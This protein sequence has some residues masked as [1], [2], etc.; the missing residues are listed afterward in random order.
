ML[1]MRDRFRLGRWRTWQCPECHVAYQL[2]EP[3]DITFWQ[4]RLRSS[5][6]KHSNLVGVSL[7]CRNCGEVTKFLPNGETAR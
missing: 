3:S 6:E 2:A 4:S 7:R 5:D 1:A